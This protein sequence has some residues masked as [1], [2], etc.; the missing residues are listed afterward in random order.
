MKKLKDLN[1]SEERYISLYGLV[2]WRGLYLISKYCQSAKHPEDINGNF[3]I[4]VMRTG[5][6]S[7]HYDYHFDVPRTHKAIRSTPGLI[8]HVDS[9]IIASHDDASLADN[10]RD[11][12]FGELLA[13]VEIFPHMKLQSFMKF[14]IDNEYFEEAEKVNKL[15]QEHK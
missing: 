4:R 9:Y 5:L 3:I 8:P 10:L 2:F 1:V 6:E 15:L 7:A 11:D 12:H 13:F 14:C